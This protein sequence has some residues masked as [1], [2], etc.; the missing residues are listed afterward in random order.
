M[1][2]KLLFL[3]NEIFIKIRILLTKL[4]IS[5]F[6][7]DTPQKKFYQYQLYQSSK[8]N[9]FTMEH[10]FRD[11]I[12]QLLGQKN[13]FG[14]SKNIIN[15]AMMI[16]WF[17]GDFYSSKIFNRFITQFW[18]SFNII[19]VI[20]LFVH[21]FCYMVL[22]SNIDISK[23]LFASQV[24]ISITY[25]HITTPVSSQVYRKGISEMFKILDQSSLYELQMSYF[26]ISRKKSNFNVAYAVL[27][28]QI[29]LFT[30]YLTF[31]YLHLIIGY[32]TDKLSD[33]NYFIYPLYCENVDQLSTFIVLQISQLISAL[34][35]GPMYFLIPFFPLIVANEF[36]NKFRALSNALKRQS[37][38]F[39]RHFE[40]LLEQSVANNGEIIRIEESFVEDVQCYAKYHH[41]LLRFGVN[42]FCLVFFRPPE[43]NFN[44]SSRA[45]SGLRSYLEFNMSMNLF[46][47]LYVE[48]LLIHIIALVR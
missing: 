11:F 39:K 7:E 23:F 27:F 29:S 31:T 44:F 20:L 45:I 22:S 46:S 32:N 10:D 4:L 16:Y 35:V 17:L 43:S 42:I 34:P 12:S 9:P 47:F 8:S 30:L 40:K 2:T 24:I 26:A 28:T 19:A 36:Y 38:E 5:V 14:Y 37:E 33:P 18:I 21:S 41:N 3:E 6:L 13:T 48:I 15:Q 1:S 25:L